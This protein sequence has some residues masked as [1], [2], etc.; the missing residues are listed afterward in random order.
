M[1]PGR[2]CKIPLRGVESMPF[3]MVLVLAFALPQTVS[4]APTTDALSVLN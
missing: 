3:P 2:E 4:S 1:F